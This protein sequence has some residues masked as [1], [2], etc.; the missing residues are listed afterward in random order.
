MGYLN[1]ICTD[2]TGRW[3]ADISLLIG[4]IVT[5][6]HN[7]VLPCGIS[8]CYLYWHNG[9]MGSWYLTVNWVNCNWHKS[10]NA[11]VAY[12]TMHHH[13]KEICLTLWE[14]CLTLWEI[15]M[16]SHNSSVQCPTIHHFITEMGTYQ[17]VCATKTHS[18][19]AIELRLSCSN[20][21]MCAHCCYKMA[22]CGIWDW[23]FVDYVRRVFSNSPPSICVMGYQNA[24]YTA[25]CVHFF[26]K[27]V[28]CGIWDW[29]IVG[30][31][32]WV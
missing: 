31:V 11:T 23:W 24:I 9:Q 19:L 27:L 22:H 13:V 21:S 30:C 4:L 8:E 18:A 32:R 17:W 16:T 14:I 20:P 12:P 6:L 2:T 28:H 5:F 3:V 29:C 1:A 25:M 15:W 7:S 10:H 26:Y